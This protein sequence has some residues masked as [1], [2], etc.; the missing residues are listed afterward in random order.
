MKQLSACVCVCVRASK[1][2]CG[3][4]L[5]TLADVLAKSSGYQGNG[6]NFPNLGIYSA[7]RLAAFAEP[8]PCLCTA[9]LPPPRP[10][11]RPARQPFLSARLSPFSPSTLPPCLSIRPS[12][13]LSVQLP[14][15]SL[16]GLFETR[17]LHSLL[18]AGGPQV[19]TQQ[20][21]DGLDALVGLCARARLQIHT[22]K[23]TG[24]PVHRAVRLC[25]VNQLR[26]VMRVG[27]AQS[28]WIGP[29]L[30]LAHIRV[31][32][33]CLWLSPASPPPTLAYLLRGSRNL[34]VIVALMTYLALSSAPSNRNKHRE[35]CALMYGQADMAVAGVHGQTLP[36]R[37]TA[38]RLEART[39]ITLTSP[40]PCFHSSLH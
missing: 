19:R 17:D 2:E 28:L 10:H 34:R 20:V 5:Y 8:S 22:Q 26:R 3:S 15:L 32:S 13:N 25:A 24:G 29:S 12:Q 18:S 23:K 16:S 36:L 35:K 11:T 7:L 38:D 27:A 33:P 14:W 4:V 37:V 30:F 40:P 9:P 31:F 1:C 6:H 39:S 21:D